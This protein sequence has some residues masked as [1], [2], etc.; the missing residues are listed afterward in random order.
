MNKLG[1]VCMPTF[2]SN[3]PSVRYGTFTGRLTYSSLKLS[4]QSRENQHSGKAY[5]PCS[6]AYGLK[7][8][9]CHRDGHKY[10]N[11]WN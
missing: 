6:K 11:K 3:M 4:L 1:L 8:P 5:I 2:R 7:S 9:L 10:C